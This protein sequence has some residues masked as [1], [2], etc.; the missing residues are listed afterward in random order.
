MPHDTDGELCFKGYNIMKGY[1]DEPVKTAETIDK[2]GWLKT[3]DIASMVKNF[4]KKML[5]LVS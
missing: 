1:W 2:N 4:N 5:F 3:G